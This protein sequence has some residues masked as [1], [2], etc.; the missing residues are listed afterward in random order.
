M[1]IKKRYFMNKKICVLGLG[2]VGLPLAAE[3]SKKYKVVGFDINSNRVEELKRGH[4][5]TLEV[6]DE[7]LMSVLVNNLSLSDDIE[8]I[9]DSHIYIVTV[10][11]PVDSHNNPDLTPLIK[12]SNMI[13]GFIKRGDIV[14]YESTTFPGCTRE[15]C[16]PEIEKHTDLKFNKDF[17]VGYSPERIN[18]GDKVNTLTKITKVTSGS[19]PEIASEVDNLYNSIIEAGTHKASSIEVAEASKIIENSQRDINIAFINELSIIF[20]RLGIDTREVLDA[21][22]TK[23]NFLKFY[24]GLVGGHC[25][26]VDPYYLARKAEEVGYHPEVILSGRRVNDNLSSFI[27]ANV[28]KLMIKNNIQIQQS[29]VLVLGIT[30]KENCPDIRNTKIADVIK[31]FQDFGCSVD[32][33]DPQASADEVKAEYGIDLIERISSKYDSIVLAVAH[34]EFLEID[35]V[36]LKNHESSIIYDIKSILPKDLVDGRL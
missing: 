29:N 18:P 1:L 4:D 15:I 36:G 5:S 28:V 20:N 33:Y 21:A 8:D 11:T 35:Y 3:F 13:G 24:P 22:G 30:F 10:P 2:Y 6:A 12:V 14:I 16:V 19:T 25:I 27:A 34:E 17:F 26:S 23:W 31:E 9:K 7:T 32:C